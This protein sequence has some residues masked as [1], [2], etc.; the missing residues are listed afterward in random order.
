MRCSNDPWRLENPLLQGLDVFRRRQPDGCRVAILAAGVGYRAEAAAD[1]TFVIIIKLRGSGPA[2]PAPKATIQILYNRS[3]AGAAKAKKAS[4]TLRT[5][6]CQFMANT[7]FRWTPATGSLESKGQVRTGQQ[8][9]ANPSW[10][11]GR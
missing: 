4:T 6:R 7:F 5:Q 10:R 3:R 2:K 11:T 1:D 8:F 9:H